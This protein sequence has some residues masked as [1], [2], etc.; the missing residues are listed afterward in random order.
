MR[1]VAFLRGINVGGHKV[2]KM[3][4]LR[5]VFEAAGLLQVATYIQ[6][7]NVIFDASTEI[8]SILLEQQLQQALGYH[9]PVMLRTEEALKTLL[10]E[11]PFAAEQHAQTKCYV[12][13]LAAPLAVEAATAVEALSTAIDTYRVAGTE[14][15]VLC[16]KAAG[17]SL[18]TTGLL[19]KTSATSA[20]VRD[21]NSLTKMAARFGITE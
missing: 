13:F 6:S 3:D 19:E 11:P 4:Q 2:I 16:R 7:G 5:A 10:A 8:E 18:F 17:R 14:V 1:Y 12:A 15:Y 21:W 20:T 9:V